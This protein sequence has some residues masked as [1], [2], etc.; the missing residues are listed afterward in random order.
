M[1]IKNKI[2]VHS[3]FY[4]LLLLRNKTDTARRVDTNGLFV[5]FLLFGIMEH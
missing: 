1:K 3:A 5:I 4:A 2:Y